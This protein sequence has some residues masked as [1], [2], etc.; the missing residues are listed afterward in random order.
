MTGVK[1]V[2]V[3]W[4]TETPYSIITGWKGEK[5]YFKLQTK[6]EPEKESTFK[7]YAYVI[8]LGAAWSAYSINM[9][10]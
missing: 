10:I 7:K 5:I 6:E 1:M 8:G 9:Q 3:F 2:T 4:K